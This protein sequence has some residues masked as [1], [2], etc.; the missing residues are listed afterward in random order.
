MKL[1]KLSR[2]FCSHECH[3]QFRRSCY[4]FCSSAPLLLAITSHP[5]PLRTI[6]TELFPKD[7]HNKLWGLYPPRVG[8]F[9]RVQRHRRLGNDSHHHDHDYNRPLHSA[10]EL[11]AM[12]SIDSTAVPQSPRSDLA[13]QNV[14]RVAVRQPM[15]GRWLVL[16]PAL[17]RVSRNALDLSKRLSCASYLTRHMRLCRFK[18]SSRYNPWLG[19]QRLRRPVQQPI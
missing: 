5:P 3:E 12:P 13:I 4:D 16:L 14:P 7:K 1:L 10:S 11:P 9:I 15:R 17:E 6:W 18:R 19:L 2:R 8:I